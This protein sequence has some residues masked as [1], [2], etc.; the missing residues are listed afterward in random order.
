MIART[1]VHNATQ[2]GT[3]EGYKQA[4]LTTKIW[5][6]VMDEATR[7]SHASIDGEE[8]PMNTPFSNG[9]MLPGDPNGPAEET[10]NCRC[11][12]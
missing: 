8:R 11:T 1:E 10:I 6:S 9:L 7:E 4:G 2:Y 5:V 12:I 3:L